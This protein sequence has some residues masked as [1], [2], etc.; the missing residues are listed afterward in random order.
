MFCLVWFKMYVY[1]SEGHIFVLLTVLIVNLGHDDRRKKNMSS[2]ARADARILAE[3]CCDSC[4]RYL[5]RGPIRMCEQRHNMCNRCRNHMSRSLFCTAQS[6]NHLRNYDLETIV[7]THIRQCP[8]DTLVAANCDF[9][10]F[11]SDIVQHVRESHFSECL[12]VTGDSEWIELPVPF[13]QYQK[14]IFKLDQLFFLLWSMN[15]D[16]L[17]LIVFHVGDEED[18]SGYTYDFKIENCLPLISSYGSTCH[19]YFTGGKEI[20]QSTKHVLFP[21]QSMMFLYDKPDVTCSVKIRRPQLIEDNEPI[22][23][24]NA[25]SSDFVQM[26]LNL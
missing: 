24:Y 21:Q 19:H 26:P 7:T 9:S 1:L 20:L 17:R 5:K 8:F 11:P 10:V 25:G 23:R 2:L 13:I 3:L 12:E 16:W 18:S 22:Y 4:G 14:A 15:A 6:S